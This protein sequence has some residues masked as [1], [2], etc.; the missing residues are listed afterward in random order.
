VPS[1][2][3]HYNYDRAHQNLGDWLATDMQMKTGDKNL[4]EKGLTFSR[5]LV[6]SSLTKYDAWIAYFTVFVPSMTY[7]FAVT[8]HSANRLRK[9]QS[10][11]TRST[12]LKLGF[13]RNTAKAVA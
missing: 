1:N 9:I 11:P 8:H 12:L 10:S 4:F 5:R 6:S 2:V 3:T 7:T 13:N